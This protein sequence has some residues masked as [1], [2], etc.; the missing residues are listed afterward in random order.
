[1]PLV[2]VDVQSMPRIHSTDVSTLISDSGITRYQLDAKVHDFYSNEGDPYQHFPEKIHVERFD[3]LYNVEGNIVADTAYYFERKELWH[4]VGNVVVKNLEGRVFETSE[5]FWDEKVPA[6]EVNA[7]YT[8]KPVKITEPD[9]T[10]QYGRNGFKADRS[11]N[12]IR[13]FSIKGEFDFVE[14]SNDSIPL[15]TIRPDSI[16][17]HE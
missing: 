11:L 13:L 1:M 14:E 3:S 12:I 17:L 8:Y 9:G 2:F 10:F 4:A 16:Q 6:D 5:L 15:N 7:F